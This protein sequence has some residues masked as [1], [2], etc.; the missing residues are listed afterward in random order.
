MAAAAVAAVGAASSSLAAESM[1]SIFT[2]QPLQLS[3][4]G[5]QGSLQ[6]VLLVSYS[7]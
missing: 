1:M 3:A 5:Q 4:C 2:L 6:L 7:R